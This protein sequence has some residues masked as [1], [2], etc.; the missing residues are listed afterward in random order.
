MLKGI[1]VSSWQSMSGERFAHD[2]VERAYLD[3]DFVIAKATEGVSYVN[4]LC[5]RVVQRAKAD[6]KLVGFYHYANGGNPSE[7]ASFLAKATEGYS[8][9]AVPCL[10]WESASNPSWGDSGWCRRFADAYHGETGVWPM[11][12]TS[13]SALPQAASCASDCALWLAGY[14]VAG[15]L[16]WNAPDMPYDVS[17]W[18]TW[19]VWQYT[20]DEG[21]DRNLGNLTR[22]AWGAIAKGSKAKAKPQEPASDVDSLAKEVMAGKWG[23]GAERRRR[24]EAAGHDY[25][26]VQSRVNELV[27]GRQT[28]HT[29]K[30]GDTLSG[31]AITYGTDWPSIAKAN[32]IKWPY[33]IYPGQKVVIPR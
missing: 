10:D 7:E 8:G 20:S 16:G 13:A 1:D 21:I 15:I 11:V 3:S 5:D 30:S 2:V 27:L 9:W 31:I 33:T 32:G 14:P 23:N 12:Y 24:L 17:P 25:L 18:K 4:P 6:G 19:T 28:V 26:K 22:E 29:V